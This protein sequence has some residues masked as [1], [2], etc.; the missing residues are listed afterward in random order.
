MVYLTYMEPKFTPNHLET[1]LAMKYDDASMK[2][3]FGSLSEENKKVIDYWVNIKG[4]FSMENI[5][6]II[7]SANEDQ[8]MQISSILGD[9]RMA[10]DKKVKDEFAL[11]LVVL[12][13]TL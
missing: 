6:D 10:T 8:R 3:K 11:A 5:V 2:E 9:I 13:N 1:G 12:L 4:D 7:L